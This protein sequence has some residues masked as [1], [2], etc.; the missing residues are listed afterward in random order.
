VWIFAHFSLTF[1]Q[2]FN[3]KQYLAC[4]H[5]FFLTKRQPGLLFIAIKKG[6]RCT[7]EKRKKK[8]KG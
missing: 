3:L 7:E 6:I 2:T 1:D 5:V 8:E 4:L